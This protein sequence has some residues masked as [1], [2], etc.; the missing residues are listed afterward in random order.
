L[1]TLA[2]ICVGLSFG[3]AMFLFGLA[4]MAMPPLPLDRWEFGVTVEGKE[5]TLE[6]N[7]TYSACIRLWALSSDGAYCHRVNR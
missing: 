6:T 2:I 4:Y 3:I 1:K 5:H 7:L